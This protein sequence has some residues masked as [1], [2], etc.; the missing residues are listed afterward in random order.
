MFVLPTMWSL[1]QQRR[2]RKQAAAETHSNNHHPKRE[3]DVANPGQPTL[4][5]LDVEKP[6]GCSDREQSVNDGKICIRA[7]GDDDPLDPHNWPLLERSK[8]IAILVYLIFVQAWA[9]AAESMANTAAS[10]QE[11]HSKI[12]EN[13]AVAMY[14]FGLANGSLLAGPVSQTVGRNPTY[15]VAASCSLCFVVGAALAPNFGGRIVCRF[16]IGFFASATLTINGSSV[17]DMFRPVKRAF[18]FPMIAWAN[19]AGKWTAASVSPTLNP[20]FID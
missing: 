5:H 9:G 11:G 4:R 10:R 3:G 13:L 15:L 14:L 1:V 17:R 2:L 19:V 8:N 16:F 12:A 18:V 6:D 7:T 20:R